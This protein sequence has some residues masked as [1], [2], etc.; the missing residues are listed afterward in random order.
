MKKIKT[1]MVLLVISFGLTITLAAQQQNTEQKKQQMM[2]MNGDQFQNDLEDLV[3]QYLKLREALASDD[4][5]SAQEHVT[6]FSSD[7]FSDIEELRA[8][9]KSIS[10]VLISRVEEEGYEGT[11]F[12]QYCPMYDSGSSW[13]SNKEDIENPFYGS[14]MHNCGETVEQM[15]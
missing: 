1:T 3:P 10:E 7:D 5:E 11:L 6:L 2:T 4:F 8:D 9:F 14:Q 12:K 15:N 13:I